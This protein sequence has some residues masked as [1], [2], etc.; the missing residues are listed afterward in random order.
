MHLWIHSSSLNLLKN[1]FYLRESARERE[2]EG[3]VG[4]SGEGEADFA[5]QKGA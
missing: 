1:I 2:H 3:G 5:A 4:R